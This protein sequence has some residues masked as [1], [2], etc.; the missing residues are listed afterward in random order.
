MVDNWSIY[1]TI[2]FSATPAMLAVW[3]DIDFTESKGAP[4]FLYRKL[5]SHSRFGPAIRPLKGNFM[6]NS[7]HATDLF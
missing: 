2:D 4:F 5:P 1:W 7:F 3:V 6:I